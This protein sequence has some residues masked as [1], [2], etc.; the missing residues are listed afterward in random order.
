MPQASP[1]GYDAAA[2]D[3]TLQKLI[4]SVSTA[5]ATCE[6]LAP[7]VTATITRVASAPEGPAFEEAELLT[8]LY[9]RMAKAGLNAVRAVDELSR[10]RSF[11]AGGPDSRPDLSHRG[12][13][14]LRQL[15]LDACDKLGF[16]LVPR[17]E[18]EC[19]P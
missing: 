2:L 14:E 16:E 8:V 18:L 7:R 10:L 19:Q 15:L 12:E 17:K 6:A 1:A 9:D 11:L 3:G 4:A 5:V 13:H